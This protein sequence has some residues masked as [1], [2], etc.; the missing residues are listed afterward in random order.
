MGAENSIAAPSAVQ[1]GACT[2]SNLT[3]AAFCKGCGHALYE[4]CPGCSKQVLLIQKFCE[5]CGADLAKALREKH[6]QNEEKMAERLL[7]RRHRTSKLR[8]RS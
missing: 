6:A 8:L 7:Q 2:T 4:P 1:C 5:S 3:N